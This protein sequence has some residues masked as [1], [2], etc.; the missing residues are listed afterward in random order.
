MLLFSFLQYA[1]YISFD[2]FLSAFLQYAFSSYAFMLLFTDIFLKLQFKLFKA[3]Q[4][5]NCGA[6]Y[7]FYLFIKAG[8]FHL[9]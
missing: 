3:P 5:F 8:L 9:K 6:Y 4:F 2:M 1:F 7:D